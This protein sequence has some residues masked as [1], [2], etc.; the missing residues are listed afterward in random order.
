LACFPSK[1]FAHLGAEA[2]P[3]S[4]WHVEAMSPGAETLLI[5]QALFRTSGE[6]V[7]I[8]N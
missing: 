2:P 8:A 3:D 7:S 6:S 4:R 5:D 1:D